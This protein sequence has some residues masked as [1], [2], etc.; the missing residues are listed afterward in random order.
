[1]LSMRRVGTLG[2]HMSRYFFKWEVG[3]EK[4]LGMPVNTGKLSTDSENN[5]PKPLEHLLGCANETG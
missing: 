2:M 4:E 5:G 1:M 3:V